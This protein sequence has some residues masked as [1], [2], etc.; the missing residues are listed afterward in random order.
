VPASAAQRAIAILSHALDW[1]ARAVIALAAV[2]LVVLVL[3]TGWMVFTRYVLNDTATWVERGAL[4]AVLW[5]AL[6]VA[7][8]GV[9]ERFHMAVEVV[10]YAVSSRLRAALR[11]VADLVLL[12]LGLAMA[13]WSWLLVGQMWPFRIPLL[14]LSQG[15][16]YVPMALCGAL[17]ALFAAEHLLRRLVG[18][19][20]LAGAGASLD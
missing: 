8:I 4:L 18:L 3:I 10:L 7:A 12:G 14:G 1:L 16:Q 20:P 17:V 5:V 9:R 6:P 19:P 13:E 2:A 15:W 11:I